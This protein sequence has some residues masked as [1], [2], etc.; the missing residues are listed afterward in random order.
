MQG[1]IEQLKDSGAV[2]VRSD[3]VTKTAHDMAAQRA[4]RPEPS[5]DLS[6]I[7]MNARAAIDAGEPVADSPTTPSPAPPSPDLLLPALP[8]PATLSPAHLTPALASPAP[9]THLN[10]EMHLFSDIPEIPYIGNGYWDEQTYMFDQDNQLGVPPS[11]VATTITHT[12][13]FADIQ[14]NQPGSFDFS[15]PA[16]NHL[17]Q[18]SEFSGLDTHPPQPEEMQ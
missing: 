3:M 5:T 15:F 13:Y 1:L 9:L 14:L 11:P 4:I 18:Y 12:P 17:P 6:F 16:H 10:A 8:S 2:K 7:D